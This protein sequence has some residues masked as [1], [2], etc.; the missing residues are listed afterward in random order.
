MKFFTYLMLGLVL[1]GGNAAVWSITL[2]YAYRGHEQAGDWGIGAVVCTV[3]SAIILALTASD[4][5]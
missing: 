5:Q 3:I 4:A 1:L 2:L